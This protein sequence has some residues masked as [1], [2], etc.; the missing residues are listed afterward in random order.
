MAGVNAYDRAS[1]A[2]FQPVSFQ[3]MIIPAQYMRQQ[4]DQLAE[5]LNQQ[6]L[7]NAATKSQL[8]KGVDDEDI[9]ISQSMDNQLRQL[10]GDLASNGFNAVGRRTGLN[11]LRDQYNTKILPIQQ[12][13]QERAALAK[14]QQQA[15][16]KDPTIK[17]NRLA[18]TIAAR[19]GVDNPQV[20]SQISG[21]SGEAL[22]QQVAQK[23][24]PFAKVLADVAP[25]T[26]ALKDPNG[27]PIAF[28]YM[29]M[30]Q[31]GATPQD[32]AAV[33]SGRD[34]IDPNTASQLAQQLYNIVDDTVSS[35][36]VYDLFK[37][38]PNSINE[39]FNSAA[40]G[41]TVAL[42]SPE[43]RNI[44]DSYGMQNALEANRLARQERAARVKA[45][46]TNK[47]KQ[48]G[49]IPAT[50]ERVELNKDQ[51]KMWSTLKDRSNYSEKD[52]RKGAFLGLFSTDGNKS[53]IEPN[54]GNR[55]K[56]F[57]KQEVDSLY[58]NYL[59]Y[60]KEQI[61][62][63]SMGGLG[64]SPGI[65]TPSN[66][67]RL[68]KDEFTSILNR[69]VDE[70]KN[71]FT[72][73]NINPNDVDSNSINDILDDIK[74]RGATADK[75]YSLNKAS[76]PDAYKYLES[77]LYS[78]GASGSLLVDEDGDPVDDMSDF[79]DKSGNL[80]KDISIQSRPG[81]GYGLY[82]SKDKEFYKLNMSNIDQLLNSPTQAIVQAGY[83]PGSPEYE[84]YRE[85]LLQRVVNQATPPSLASLGYT[86]PFEEAISNY[87]D[88]LMAETYTDANKDIIGALSRKHKPVEIT[89]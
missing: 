40:S 68:S 13:V 56:A 75:V 12:S 88:D 67:L 47:N 18:N 11:K 7:L 32:I 63:P 83:T 26:L 50:V 8:I 87:V 77:E 55:T 57:S 24:A 65:S 3:E 64:F 89:Q 48:A 80:K 35:A 16:M 33:M 29:Q 66:T 1:F 4:E 85:A 38:D 72:S 15:L 60:Y 42:G 78:R 49:S 46:A 45:L 10:A 81:L 30:M 20:W 51:M 53:F 28:Q 58:D 82:N 6:Q 2:Q 73:L 41:V 21:I 27:R 59:K 39:L 54:V 74:E 14:F 44:T 17:F 9:E 25:Q 84:S 19:E 5:D 71:Y 79:I 34:G 23:V 86:G 70:N 76:F 52:K 43:I 22:R 37:D 69:T 62:D 36:G 31:R 61:T